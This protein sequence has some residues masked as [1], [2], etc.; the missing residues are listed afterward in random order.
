MG[1]GRPPDGLQHV[2][3]LK[4]SREPKKRLR[5]IFAA[6]MNECTVQ[7][8]CKALGIRPARFHQLRSKAL[9]GALCGLSPGERGRPRKHKADE[10]LTSKVQSLERMVNQLQLKLYASE[11]RADLQLLDSPASQKNRLKR[12]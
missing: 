6:M 10:E 5:W 8:A 12:K 7:E 4:G 11:L 1:A 2:L 3:R 9:K